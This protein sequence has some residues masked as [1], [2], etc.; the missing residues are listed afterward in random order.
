MV[1]KSGM[2]IEF[3]YPPP[4]QTLLSLALAACLL[5]LLPILIW[6]QEA[7]SIAQIVG[8]SFVCPVFFSKVRWVVGGCWKLEILRWNLSVRRS[9]V[10]ILVQTQ[11][12][13]PSA[14]LE[15]NWFDLCLSDLSLC[16]HGGGV[17]RKQKWKVSPSISIQ[18]SL[19]WF[20]TPDDKSN[21]HEYGWR[22]KARLFSFSLEKKSAFIFCCRHL[23]MKALQDPQI[24]CFVSLPM[25]KTLSWR[26]CFRLLRLP[27]WIV[28]ILVLDVTSLVF[29]IEVLWNLKANRGAS[30][31]LSNH[32]SKLQLSLR[33]KFPKVR[34]G[35][36]VT[37]NGFLFKQI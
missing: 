22:Q 15:A 19:T 17:L 13:N 26:N 20:S 30:N 6:K 14:D 29:P 27:C 7:A 24:C 31:R 8:I 25:R 4:P 3:S 37:Y 18:S 33:S 36:N 10:T 12:C 16:M 21:H 32:I 11:S 9:H 23:K 1:E 2:V 5:P 34:L 28:H 35:I